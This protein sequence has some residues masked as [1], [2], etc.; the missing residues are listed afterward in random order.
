MSSNKL[1]PNLKKVLRNCIAVGII[2]GVANYQNVYPPTLE[3]LYSV[4]TGFIIAFALEF[5][6]AYSKLPQPRGHRQDMST[7]FLS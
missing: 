6:H 2:A 1:F 7:F 5:A 3:M 4:I